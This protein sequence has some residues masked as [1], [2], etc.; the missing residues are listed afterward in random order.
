MYI[1]KILYISKDAHGDSFV[2]GFY[3]IVEEKPT[4]FCMDR[5]VLDCRPSRWIWKDLVN[6]ASIFFLTSPGNSAKVSS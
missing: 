4:L 5:N 1:G 2:P 3:M 6:G